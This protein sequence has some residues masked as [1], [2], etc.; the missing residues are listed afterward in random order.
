MKHTSVVD[1][2]LKKDHA[3]KRTPTLLTWGLVAVFVFGSYVLSSSGNKEISEPEAEEIIKTID[4]VEASNDRKALSGKG[5]SLD[6]VDKIETPKHRQVNLD[7]TRRQFLMRKNNSKMIIYDATDSYTSEE[8]VPLG[9]MIK[10]LLVHN[11]VSN[12][13]QSPVIAQVWEDFYFNDQLLLPFG[14]RIYGTAV[15]GRQRDRILVKFHSIVFQD[16]KTIKVDAIG[17]SGD[18]SG[19]LTG[20][21]VDDR[22]KKIFVE[23]AVNFLSGLA[24]G[25]QDTA[26]NAVTGLTQ[27]QNT[28][29]NAILEGTANTFE[30]EAKRIQREV[31]NAKG[32]AIILAGTEIIIYFEKPTDV[33]P[34]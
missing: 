32:Y 24:L 9:S 33:N 27:V 16:G 13:F 18:G 25:L 21:I 3:G 17:M 4:I 28:S 8:V 12:N 6:E 2:F 5:V 15:A 34:I 19:G 31:E 30:K 1:W 7:D 23:M 22:N 14:T 11:I 20:H 26:T 29:H 10:C